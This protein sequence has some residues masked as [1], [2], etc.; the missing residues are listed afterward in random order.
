MV[1]P[2]VRYPEAVLRAKCRPITEVSEETRQLA[3]NMLETMRAAN[4]VGL[5]APQV[6]VDQQLAVIDV[7]HNPECISYLRVNG[8]PADMVQH[9]PV[10]FLNPRLELGKAKET[11]E[12]G[13]L[14][15]PSLR[16]D[17]RR[18]AD[19]KVTFQTLEGQTITMETDG[20][21]ARA[22]QHEIDHLNGIL[23]IDRMSAA[24]KVSLKRKLKRLMEEWEEE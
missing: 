4:G 23:F 5:A 9:M 11:D 8:E 18:S 19:I 2:I 7:S 12:E 24:A 20:L 10:V 13:C 3:D 14:S 22:F 1:L 16:G 21:L 15:F 6:G 17:I